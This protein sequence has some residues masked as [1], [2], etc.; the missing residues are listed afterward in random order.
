[1]YITASTYGGIDWHDSRTIHEQLKSNGSYNIEKDKVPEAIAEDIAKDF[2]YVEDIREK[3]LQALSEKSC[4][5]FIIKSEEKDSAGNA[6]YQDCAS[7]EA[8]GQIYY[9]SAAAFDGGKQTLT[10][11]YAFGQASYTTAYYAED[12]PNSQL[13]YIVTEDFL[14]P[15]KG[16]PV[17]QRMYH[18]IF[19]RQDAAQ[20]Y[21][22]SLQLH[23]FQYP[24][25]IVTFLVCNK[26]KVSHNEWYRLQKEAMRLMDEKGQTHLDGSFHIFVKCHIKNLKRLPGK[27]TVK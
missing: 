12:I 20:I 16:V 24:A 26:G 7:Y 19:D 9:E 8:D 6:S 3:V 10:Q 5:R 13:G 15:V 11:E 23:E 4:F 14:A 2:P 18:D 1:M 22:E 25:S 27:E 17:V 21:A